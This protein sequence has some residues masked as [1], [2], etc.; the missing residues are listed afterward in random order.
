MMDEWILLGNLKE[1]QSDTHNLNESL[2]NYAEQKKPT[3]PNLHTALLYDKIIGK[4]NRLVIV[5]D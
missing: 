1:K 2:E 5:R 3:P 4:E